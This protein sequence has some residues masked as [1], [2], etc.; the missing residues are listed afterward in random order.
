MAEWA[1]TYGDTMTSTIDPISYNAGIEAADSVIQS[2]SR[3][4][5]N[6][7]AWREPPC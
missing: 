7:K 5:P 4:L 2:G 3:R 6:S 1:C